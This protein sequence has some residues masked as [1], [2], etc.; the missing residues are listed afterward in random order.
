MNKYFSVL[1][2]IFVSSLLL[3]CKKEKALVN[4]DYSKL[5]NEVILQTIK[6]ESCDCVLEISDKSMIEERI[7]DDPR[8]ENDY[9][10][11]V[12][13]ILN[14]RDRKE[15]D[16]LENLT[17]KFT[18]DTVLLKQ[19]NIKVISRDTFR[20]YF[21]DPNYLKICP[22]DLVSIGKPFFNK[23]HKKVLVDYGYYYL[24]SP[25]APA[26]YKHENGKWKRE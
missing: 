22:K 17:R 11:W 18:L 26:I 21:R 24:S 3:S 16:S 13:K 19:H 20:K 15:L 12:I 25:L 7:E 9:R 14:L 10:K 8:N 2:F 6:D 1:I 23:E 4:F 5:A